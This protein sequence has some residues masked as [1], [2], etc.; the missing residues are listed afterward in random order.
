MPGNRD[1]FQKAMNRGHSAAWDQDWNQAAT[2]YRQALEEF[3]DN[4][5]ALTSLG[6]AYFQMQVFEEA[7]K[8]YLHAA[9]VKPE[10]PVPLE[11]AFQIFEHIGSLE[12]ACDASF[13]AAEL[14]AKMRDVEKAIECWTNV[15]RLDPEHLMAH[16]RLAVVYERLG[17]KQQA[18][19][20]YTA[21]AS[22]LQHKG[23]LS[24]AIQTI[25]YAMQALPGSQQLTQALAMLKANRMLPKPIR[26]RG[27]TGPL[28][29]PQ[30]R[31]IE[32][33]ANE[34]FA[35]LDP[36]SDGRQKAMTLLAS[37]LF[38][39]D[40]ESTGSA[41]Q[42]LQSIVEGVGSVFSRQQVD[43][44]RIN[45]HLSQVIDFQTRGNEAD[46]I[47][48]LERAISLGLDHPAAYF[49]L[50]LMSYN[51]GR[52]ESALRNLKKTTAI[53]QFML[54]SRLLLGQTYRKMD[55]LKDAAVEYLEAL[56]IADS[57]VVAPERSEELRQL[58]DPI[59]ESHSQL[60][61]ADA[62]LR[63]CDNVQELLLKEDWQE[64]LRQSRQQ[65]PQQDGV[66]PLLPL[67]EILTASSSSQ[68]VESISR[69]HQQAQ[70]GRWRSAMEEAYWAI[71]H[72]PTYLP[73]H[74]YIGDLL[75]RQGYN[76]EAI[77]KFSVVARSYSIRGEPQRAIEQ[78]N[79]ILELSPTD[80]S[81]R[82]QLIGQLVAM[83]KFDAAIQQYINL[84]SV[85]YSRAELDKARQ[86]YSD[87]LQLTQH[88]GVDP[89]W[90][91]KTLH[92]MADIDLQSLDWRQ[93][94]R[95]FEQIRALDPDDEKVRRFLTS[96][97]LRLGQQSQAISELDNYL[98]YL[99]NK[100]EVDMA[101]SFLEE[102][103]RE[104]PDIVPIRHRLAELYRQQGRVRNSI[105]QLDAIAEL[106]LQA[107]DKVAASKVLQAIIRLNPENIEK[108]RRYLQDVES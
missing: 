10:D 108:Y 61:Q 54:P 65:L 70:R 62:H 98:S 64:S 103:I 78:L 19:T 79:R 27:G 3:P 80:I 87:A 43:Y 68:V 34:R 16:S 57:R 91:V 49:E 26:P 2:Y 31:Q 20:E 85:Y 82:Q 56:R 95:V 84:A 73:L 30:V 25:Q 15:T 44:S 29:M 11:K 100:R 14:Y 53:E 41:S 83:R 9:R 96:L 28:R 39:G 48:E 55:Q 93:A 92:Q 74:S 6:L 81:A 17:Q 21:I 104:H 1:Q 45:L 89:N 72:A 13:R 97:H 102:I 66:G 24:K 106:L 99:I 63:V 42:G 46:A 37:M 90:K 71:Q 67:A 105:E 59:I 60:E 32:S 94:L 101:V 36:I 7:L 52:L 76:R 4:P 35:R 33:P 77:E 22:L 58:Y 38:E 40:G 69:I 51:V 86:T 12:K 88:P 75:V 23:D 8:S 18:I 107:G 5:K 47:G 50:G